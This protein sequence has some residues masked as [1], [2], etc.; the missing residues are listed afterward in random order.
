MGRRRRLE[1]GVALRCRQCVT[2][3]SIDFICV[4]RGVSKRKGLGPALRA[5]LERHSRWGPD[6]FWK[7]G[8]ADA[9]GR[10]RRDYGF[11]LL[12]AEGLTRPD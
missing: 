2:E 6:R 11:N 3:E 1:S 7:P 9:T 4:L 5:H 12:V 10:V 8:F